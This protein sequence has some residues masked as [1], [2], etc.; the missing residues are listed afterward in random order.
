MTPRTVGPTTDASL[1][2]LLQASPD[3]IDEAF[4]RLAGELWKDGEAT[5]E[6]LPSVPALVAALAVADGSRQGHLALLLG[7]LAET[8]HTAAEQPLTEAVRAGLDRYL[9]LLTDSAAG[10]PLQL[11][12]LYLL[13]HLGGDRER[14]LAAAAGTELTPD[15]RT[16][17]ERCLQPLDPQDVVLGRVWP[18][19][20]EWQLNADEV[21]FD[22]GWIQNLSPEALAATW[23]SDT[24][25]VF[26]YTGAKALW[27]LRNGT[28]T[29]V[30]D[31]SVHAG[32]RPADPPA[33]RIEEFSRFSDVL[34]CPGCRGGLSY[35]AE[36]AACTVCD[37]SYPLP[38]GVL[39]LSAGAGDNHGESD[40]LQNAAAMRGIGFHYENVLRPAFLRVMGQNWGGQVTPT[41]EDAYLA[42][43]L[44][45]ADGPVLDVAA[46]A[47]RWTAVVAQT[48]GADNVLALDLIA[49]MLA[50]LRARLPEIATLR[51][52]ALALPVA[53]GSLAAVN[54]WN[55]LQALPDAGAAIDE[56]GRALRPG[57]RLTLL[58]FRWGSDPLYRYF[59][60]SHAFPGSPDGIKLF[61]AEQIRTWLNGA[62]LSIVE[63]SG[64]GTFVLITAEKQA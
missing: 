33:P 59:Q 58:T 30:H 46:G 1:T 15:D 13:S 8:E 6:A 42:E 50:G 4:L 14:I 21:A 28:P 5:E 3:R 40:V 10:G 47:G 53:D 51:A 25:S 39:D 19:P 62:G 55:A 11:G 43:H 31:T 63:E 61:E 35:E 9:P 24:R 41:D 32:A 2:A 54:C 20:H 18:S 29:V 52:S 57:G 12:A 7:L 38:N 16:R 23:A 27:A 17:L 44:A 45:P 34:R 49:P 60:G 36:G 37:R 56:I 26:A 64:P 48:T 22:Q